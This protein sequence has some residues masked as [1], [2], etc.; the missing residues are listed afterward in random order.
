[1]SNSPALVHAI[2]ARVAVFDNGAKKGASIPAW[3]AVKS[4]PGLADIWQLHF[5]DGG[6][7]EHNASDPF[8][9]NITEADTGFYLK[10]EADQDG[11]FSVFNSRN[12]FSKEYQAK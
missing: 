4:S 10:I 12:K 2:G 8:I 3:D 1:M 11:S 9:A 7:K 6:G 5:A